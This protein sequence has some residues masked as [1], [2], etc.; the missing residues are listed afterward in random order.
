MGVVVEFPELLPNMELL[1]NG[2]N[3][4][5]R[6]QFEDLLENSMLVSQCPDLQCF[7]CFVSTYNVLHKAEFGHF[8]FQTMGQQCY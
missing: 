2:F 6:N 7:T 8:V 4:M 1:S 3:S 5:F